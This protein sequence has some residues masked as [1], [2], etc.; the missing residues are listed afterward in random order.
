MGGGDVEMW[1][2]STSYAKWHFGET[3]TGIFILLPCV[4]KSVIQTGNDFRL[5]NE[6]YDKTIAAFLCNL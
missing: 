6:S 4:A 2:I 3:M 5:L 1:D